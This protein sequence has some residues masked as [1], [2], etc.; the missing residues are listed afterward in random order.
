MS[1]VPLAP[2]DS[3]TAE[4]HVLCSSRFFRLHSYG[5]HVQKQMRIFSMCLGAGPETASDGTMMLA[6]QQATNIWTEFRQARIDDQTFKGFSND[7]A[8]SLGIPMYVFLPKLR[9]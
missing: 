5:T 2:F 8:Q 9:M 6:I 3:L 1:C 4:N 7:C